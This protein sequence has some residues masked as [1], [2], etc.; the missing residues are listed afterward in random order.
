MARADSGAVSILDEDDRAERGRLE[1]VLADLR[2][3]DRETALERNWA[4]QTMSEAATRLAET[5]A[6]GDPKNAPTRKERVKGPFGT[7]IL[8]LDQVRKSAAP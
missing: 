1:T 6:R 4:E 7:K 8:T 3:I 5:L 2:A